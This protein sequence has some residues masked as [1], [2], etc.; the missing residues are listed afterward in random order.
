[1]DRRSTLKWIVAAVAST[2]SLQ[3]TAWGREER[4]GPSSA[5][6]TDYHP[7]ASG[8]GS[9]PDLLKIYVSGELW[10]LT[11][12]S[13]QR[14]LA[15]ILS[16]LIIPADD[17]SPSAS[18]VG[19]VAFID[20]WISAPYRL[21]QQD[22]RIVLDGFAWLDRESHLRYSK[23]FVDI[24]ETQ[25]HVICGDICHLAKAQPQFVT[26]AK[27]FSRYRNLTAGGYYTTPEGRTDIGYVGNM[28]SPSFAGPPPDV[29]KKAGLV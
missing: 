16:D 18:M 6:M 13:S 23:A 22:R 11:F 25:R 5:L 20:E 12:T 24:D 17:I 15:T 4:A 9:D 10:P 19:T 29:L 14:R 8:Y 3:R 21:Q 26:A 7:T 1:M 28:S 2:P 27:F